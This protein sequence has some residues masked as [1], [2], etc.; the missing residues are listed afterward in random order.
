MTPIQGTG[1]VSGRAG[2]WTQ[3]VWFLTTLYLIICLSTFLLFLSS[4]ML[5]E[6]HV[7]F[8]NRAQKDCH[9]GQVSVP[10]TT[11]WGTTSLLWSCTMHNLH[12]WTWQSHLWTS[13]GSPWP[14]WPWYQEIC[15]ELLVGGENIPG[16]AY[17]AL[18][19]HQFWEIQSIPEACICPQSPS[20]MYPDLV[21]RWYPWAPPFLVSSVSQWNS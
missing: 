19:L 13:P 10:Q 5:G 9:L 3:V 15:W 6:E 21:L 2:I 18:N 7:R 12:N 14:L 16:N 17:W 8:H 4:V 1:L 11:M 20:E